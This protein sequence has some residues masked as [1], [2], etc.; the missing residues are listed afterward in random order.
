M[1]AMK[2]M[3]WRSGA[4]LVVCATFAGESFSQRVEKVYEK[5]HD[6]MVQAIQTGQAAGVLKGPV[7]ALFAKGMQADGPLRGHAVAE[8][9]LPRQGCKRLKVTYTQSGVPTTDRPGKQDVQ[10]VTHI[11]YC[12]DGMPPITDGPAR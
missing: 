2:S 4:M 5:P 7:S 10:L 8:S 3:N 1:Q 9:A 11:N 12:L 6:L